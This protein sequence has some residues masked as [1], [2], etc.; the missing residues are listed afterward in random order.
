MKRWRCIVPHCNRTSGTANVEPPDNAWICSVHY[1]RVPRI[2]KVVRARE[3]RALRR[4]PTDPAV[5]ARYVRLSCRV[6]QKA[7][8]EA[9]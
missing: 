4:W 6:T 2:M 1:G 8:E 3:R 7:I 5:V 9:L